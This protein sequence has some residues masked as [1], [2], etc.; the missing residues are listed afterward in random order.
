MKLIA[1][2]ALCFLTLL[3]SA[4]NEITTINLNKI[5]DKKTVMKTTDFFELVEFI[6]LETTP[7]CLTENSY[8]VLTSDAIYMFSQG[9]NCILKF[10][11]QGKF[12]TKIGKRGRGPGEFCTPVQCMIQYYD[13]FIYLTDLTCKKS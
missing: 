13:G 11:R 9:Q 6:P 8:T 5:L 10:N 1:F 2:I 7:E 12:I 3:S 4:Q